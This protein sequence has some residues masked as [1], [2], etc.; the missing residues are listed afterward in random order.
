MKLS[1]RSAES[2]AEKVPVWRE[3]VRGAGFDA[4]FSDEDL[5][6]RHLDC[7]VKNDHSLY[8][9]GYW[10]ALLTESDKSDIIY[11]D[12]AVADNVI[13]NS[14]K[15]ERLRVHGPVD[16]IFSSP[17]SR[18]LVQL[19]EALRVLSQ[20]QERSNASDV[21][22]CE[23]VNHERIARKSRTLKLYRQEI[24]EIQGELTLSSRRESL[25]AIHKTIFSAED[26]TLPELEVQSY[27]GM[28]MSSVEFPL[29][30]GLALTILVDLTIS[31]AHFVEPGDVSGDLMLHFFVHQENTVFSHAANDRLVVEISELIPML[32]YVRFSGVK[33]LA[34]SALCWREVFSTT[35]KDLVKF[36]RAE[37]S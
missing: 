4:S 7:D 33:E 2:L 17:R 14:R 26:R 35:F 11:S 12:V 30:F 21:A 16:S 1:N 24:S 6:L 34:L 3:Q 19:S 8:L 18:H 9:R 5:V 32:S 29:E 15:M 22:F 36:I 37:P 23:L 28:E 27:L 31:P 10:K 13:I 20:R 25:G